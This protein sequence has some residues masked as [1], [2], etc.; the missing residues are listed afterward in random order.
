MHK[1]VY[2]RHLDHKMHKMVYIRHLDRDIDIQV[3]IRHGVASMSRTHTAHM[4]IAH[5]GITVQ[6]FPCEVGS[7][8]SVKN[9]F[10]AINDAGIR[11]DYVI[12]S[13]CISPNTDFFE[14]TQ[15]EWDTV[16]NTNTT[17][18]FLVTKYAALFM[19]NNPLRDDFRGRIL[20]V[21]STNGI[22]SQDPVSAHYDSSKAAGNMLVR[23]AAERLSEHQICVNA[24]AP[25]WIATALNDSLPPDVREKETAKIWMRRWARPEE[26]AACAAHILAMPYYMGQVLMADASS[27]AG[28]C[29][30]G[31]VKAMRMWV[32]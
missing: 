12:N 28:K 23:T 17:G 16:H 21:T 24:L 14:Q 30:H 31:D 22:N 6:A 27:I 5:A 11:I 20:L 26:M 2:I 19:K 15:K 7:E 29:A 10:T 9:F 8:D 18:A 25:G 1:M 13:A 3:C 32:V 4:Q